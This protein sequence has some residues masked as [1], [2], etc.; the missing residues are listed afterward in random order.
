MDTRS[1]PQSTSSFSLP[2]IHFYKG[3]PPMKSDHARTSDGMP[4]GRGS[5]SLMHCAKSMAV[6]RKHIMS[7]N[8]LQ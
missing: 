1:L 2:A 3:F 7:A 4:S 5:F 6:W 8:N